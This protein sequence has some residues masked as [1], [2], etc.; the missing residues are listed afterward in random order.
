[1][2]LVSASRPTATFIPAEPGNF[3]YMNSDLAFT[4][5]YVIQGNFQG[6]SI[7]DIADPSGPKLVHA[8]TCPDQQNDV[9]VYK[10][11]LFLS[12]ESQ[13]GR[14]DCG[15]QGVQEPVSPQRFR[16]VRVLDISDLNHPR[17][18]ANVQTCRGSHTHTLVTDPK[19]SSVVYIYVS[20]QAPVRA[21]GELAGCSA[22][23][24]EQDTASA[25]F[26]IDIIRVPLA[27][28]EQA[29]IVSRP[30]IFEALVAPP[31]HGPTRTDSAADVRYADSARATGAFV[32]TFQGSPVVLPSEF[33]T[34]MLD[35]IVRS[36]G[37]SGAPTAADS[38]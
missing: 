2:R 17:L 30:R 22:A 12:G 31:M 13:N 19:D 4:G 10:N 28:P 35:S 21:A 32:V 34:G 37:A 24:P 33:T 25:R 9:S 15:A 7:W 11:V 23:L 14:V 5:H 6:F 3:D 38:T 18:L 29:S 27:H 8:E 26:R 1:M 16:G 20:G 36:R